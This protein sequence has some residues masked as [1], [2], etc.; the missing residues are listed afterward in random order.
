MMAF[1]EEHFVRSGQW[2]KVAFPILSSIFYTVIYID[3]H[4]S[5]STCCIAVCFYSISK[6]SKNIV[7]QIRKKTQELLPFL[8]N[9]INLKLKIDT[10]WQ[11]HNI[12]LFW[13]QQ[14]IYIYRHNLHNEKSKNKTI[15]NISVIYAIMKLFRNSADHRHLSLIELNRTLCKLCLYIYIYCCFQK[16]YIL[17]LCHTV[18][19]FFIE[20]P[21][22]NKGNNKITEHRAIF[23]SE[24]QNA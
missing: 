21:V 9:S 6:S 11:R 13:K 7:F 3:W 23:Q 10:V 19:I 4:V 15:N 24:R 8:F 17:C 12:Y 5:V 18:S 1:E 22:P 2:C 14:Y 16:R 20:V